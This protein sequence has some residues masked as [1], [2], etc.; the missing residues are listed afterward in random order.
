M[1]NQRLRVLSQRQ[2][3]DFHRDGYL[4]VPDVYSAAEMDAALAATDRITYGCTFAEWSAKVAAGEI[5]REVADGIGRKDNAG[6]PQFP[7]GVPELDRLLESQTFLDIVCDVIGTDQIHYINGHLFVR[8]GPTDRRHP[9][10]PWE[11]FHLDHDTG[12]FL[13]PWNEHGRFDYVGC[14]VLLHDIGEDCAP[15][16]LVPGSHR[17]SP[18]RRVQ[19]AREGLMTPRGVVPDVRKI[20]EFSPRAVFTGKRGSVGF[21]TTH[22]LHAAVPFRDKSLQRAAWTMSVGRADTMPMVRFNNAFMYGEREFT[23]PFWTK[24]SPRVRSFFGWPPPGHAY[25]T[26]ETLEL[27]A[28]QYP[29]MDLSPYAAALGGAKSASAR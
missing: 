29:G 14:G 13:P 17:L 10:H 23:I 3:D 6:R 2:L 22:L 5:T 21:S 28:I 7:T 18:E 19:L 26:R 1:G 12:S 4:V 16:V 11:G 25:Y 15:T 20:P 27:L 8:A 9:D 24:T